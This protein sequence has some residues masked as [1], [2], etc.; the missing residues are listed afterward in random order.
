MLTG[1]HFSTNSSVTCIL[2]A[3]F[4]FYFPDS[5]FCFQITTPHN[6]N[7]RLHN[8]PGSITRDFR[9]FLYSPLF[10]AHF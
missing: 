4:T 7:P 9:L 2:I 5:P 8:S 6:D 10:E 3:T 1:A